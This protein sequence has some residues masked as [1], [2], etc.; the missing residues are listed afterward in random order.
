MIKFTYFPEALLQLSSL[1]SEID[2][3]GSKDACMVSPEINL[4]EQSTIPNTSSIPITSETEKDNLIK[5][6]L[7]DNPPPRSSSLPIIT[8]AK[9]TSTSNSKMHKCDYE[10]CTYSSK[11]LRD[12]T[13]HRR[14]HTGD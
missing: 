7:S 13:R 11:Y 10:K 12:L 3:N 9:S 6:E 1:A 8:K 2:L 5:I 14:K 4:E